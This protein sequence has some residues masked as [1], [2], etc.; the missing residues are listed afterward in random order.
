MMRWLMKNKH[1]LKSD[2]Y[3]LHNIGM[4]HI[5]KGDFTKGKEFLLKSIELDKK[6]PELRHALGVAIVNKIIKGRKDH[7]NL[8]NEDV[9]QLEFAEDLFTKAI[10]LLGPTERKKQLENIYIHRSISRAILDKRKEAISDI[11]EAIDLNPKNPVAY[12][13]R[14]KVLMADGQF[15]EAVKDYELAIKM[16]ADKNE[17]IPLIVSAYIDSPQPLPEEALRF[18]NKAYTKEELNNQLIP[19]VML[20]YCNIAK[21][22]FEKSQK[23]LNKLYTQFGRKI[24]IINAEARLEKR[25][26]NYEK[27]EK[28]IKEIIEIGAGVEQ[29]L[30][31]VDLAQY[32]RNFKKFDEAAP[33]FEKLLVEGRV[34][35]ALRDYLLCLYN[36]KENRTQN[37]EKCLSI[38]AGFQKR[39]VEDPCLLEIQGSIYEEL[40]KIEEAAEAL[41]KLTL[42]EKTIYRHQVN[43]SIALI[44]IGGKNNL[45]KA[46][47]IL[48][49]VKAKIF[50]DKRYLELFVKGMARLGEIEEAIRSAYQLIKIDSSNADYQ[51]LYASLFLSR[52]KK[53][54]FLEP[55]EIVGD[56]WIRLNVN[57]NE[58]A[59]LITNDP[60]PDF[61]KNEV[62]INSEFGKII[63]GKKLGD[64]FDIKSKG[65]DEK[66]KVLEIKSKFVK[67]YQDI[68]ENFNK[69]FP[70][71][72]D[73]IKMD[74]TKDS[75]LVEVEKLLKQR[76]EHV[77]EIV[78]YYKNKQVTIGALALLLKVNIYET[79]LGLIKGKGSKLYCAHGSIE[80]QKD[81]LGLVIN[82][83]E[84]LIDPIA[85]FTLEH[86]KLLEIL[87]LHFKKVYIPVFFVEEMGGIIHDLEIRLE[88]QSAVMYYE[89]GKVKG[90]EVSAD[91]IRAHLDFLKK[92]QELIGKNLIPLGF[93]KMPD[94][95][96][97]KRDTAFGKTYA[98]IIQISQENNIPCFS[99]DLMFRQI[100]KE[101][102]IKSFGVQSF[103]TG[104]WN[105]GLIKEQQYYDK[106]I[107]IARLKYD[108]LSISAPV[109][110]Y[111][112]TKGYLQTDPLEEFN[113]LLEILRD[114][115]STPL[116]IAHVM[117]D[118]I[119]LLCLEK[120]P[121][122]I[123]ARIFNLTL[124]VLASKIEPK[125]VIP[126]LKKLLPAKLGLVDYLTPQIIAEAKQWAQSKY[127]I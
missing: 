120:L 17:I 15:S 19:Q 47:H 48:L 1:T 92:I 85:L 18:L 115:R 60:N 107:S 94:A 71:S 25:T 37:V 77:D 32:Y 30:A 21:N 116:S 88:Q 9:I 2:S 75:F 104:T 119:K 24:Q 98:S 68:M 52:G 8:T 53:M 5:A 36:S 106:V 4:A 69:L 79:W 67:L 96:A 73:L 31:M 125:T 27:Y 123:R 91:E 108:Y 124:D 97:Q 50:N 29:V 112:I 118:F 59:Y 72:R 65:T 76:S 117:T 10:K 61:T 95:N 40:G 70:E 127:I 122:E 62:Y 100:S 66:L 102:G 58:K 34:D 110:L 51:M 6:N 22:D 46:R 78:T 55:K 42:L 43:Y 56:S 105:K 23:L 121:S 81:E 20:V 26:K 109:L 44:K 101:F 11:S 63:S 12:D 13:Q 28:L 64:E 45:T 54:K 114:P 80:E 41:H 14:A 84:I 49:R 111:S 90:I 113:I 82:V 16:G 99:D 103:L 7:F 33:L 83:Q 89:E 38:I 3:S 74:G 86:L 35:A 93:D 39:G 57:G 126:L 87:C